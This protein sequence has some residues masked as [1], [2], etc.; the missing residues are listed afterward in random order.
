MNTYEK[1]A[2]DF[3]TSTKTKLTIEKAIPQKSPLWCK[4]GEKHGINYSVTL[5]NDRHVYTFDFWNSIAKAEMLDLAKKAKE[6]GIYSKEYYAVKDFLEKE[7][8][9][10]VPK[11]IR[12]NRTI[13]INDIIEKKWFNNIVDTVDIAITPTA[14]DIL[15]CL[16]PL[17]ENNFEDFCS[18]FGYDVD[19][20]KAKKTYNACLKQDSN[21]GKLFSHDE[22]ERLAEIQ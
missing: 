2:I 6:Y 14:Y 11:I 18:S 13:D 10:T 20:I 12:G 3:L 22:L 5:K 21:L 8:T 9:E 1:Q 19:S 15:A 16:S 7:A 4:E 17:Y